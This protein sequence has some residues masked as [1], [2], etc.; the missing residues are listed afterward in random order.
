MHPLHTN[1]CNQERPVRPEN[2]RPAERGLGS[3]PRPSYP[4]FEKVRRDKTRV[5]KVPVRP[6]GSVNLILD[7]LGKQKTAT[8]PV[9]T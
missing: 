9:P 3:V 4:W 5:L 6:S 1:V 7:D 8:G 2:L